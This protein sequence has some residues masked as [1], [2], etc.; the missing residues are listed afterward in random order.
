MLDDPIHQRREQRPLHVDLVAALRQ[1]FAGAHEQHRGV[2]VRR[3]D[4]G[5]ARAS[6]VERAAAVVERVDAVGGV[7]ARH[8]AAT[9]AE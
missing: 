1:R 3:L 5:Q 2:H 7:R 9:L 6:E 4:E 8:H